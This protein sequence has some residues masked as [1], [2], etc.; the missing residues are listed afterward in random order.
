MIIKL[1]T[2]SDRLI[3]LH[4]DLAVEWIEGDG[5]KVRSDDQ[6]VDRLETKYVFDTWH[7]PPMKIAV[8]L[9]PEPYPRGPCSG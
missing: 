4:S 8:S 1:A 7:L 3:L 9:C 5:G 6:D 2:T